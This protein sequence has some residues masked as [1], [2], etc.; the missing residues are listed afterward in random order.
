MY[1]ALKEI[2]ARLVPRVQCTI[3]M[4]TP[5]NKRIKAY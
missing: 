2:F 3:I 1:R 5:Y 4:Y